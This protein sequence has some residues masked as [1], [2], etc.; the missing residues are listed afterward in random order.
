[1]PFGKTLIKLLASNGYS[2]VIKKH[3]GTESCIVQLLC[4]LSFN[5]STTCVGNI[6][7]QSF[8]IPSYLR[9]HQ[10]CWATSFSA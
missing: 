1:M 2:K 8:Y 5:M 4:V 3:K 7:I 9:H 6:N 10:C